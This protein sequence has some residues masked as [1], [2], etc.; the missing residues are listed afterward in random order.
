MQAINESSSML[1]SHQIAADLEEAKSGDVV[2]VSA[3][4]SQMTM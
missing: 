4:A 2:A 1:M 3:A